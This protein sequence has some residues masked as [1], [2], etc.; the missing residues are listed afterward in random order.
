MTNYILLNI[1]LTKTKVV[2]IIANVKRIIVNDKDPIEE[3][4]NTLEPKDAAKV[5]DRLEL[6]DEVGLK[7][8]PPY[9]KKLQNYNLYEYRVQYRRNQYRILFFTYENLIIL[10]HGFQYKDK[11]PKKEIEIAVVRK[12]DFL[13]ELE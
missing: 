11:I 2:I 12:E 3:F 5:L 4:I 13:K 7:L 8:G 10:V 9:I 6:L 1:I